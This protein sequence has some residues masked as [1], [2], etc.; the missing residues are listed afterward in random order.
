M[1]K[2]SHVDWRE[3]LATHFY[4]NMERPGRLFHMLLIGLRRNACLYLANDR[5]N[6][7]VGQNF[8]HG[9]KRDVP[10]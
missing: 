2:S 3:I 1:E 7:L 4:L 10:A 8:D 5:F 9:A 6:G